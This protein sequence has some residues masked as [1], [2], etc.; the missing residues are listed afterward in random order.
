MCFTNLK[1]LPAC[2]ADWCPVSLKPP[3][4]S[5]PSTFV[6]L[7][8]CLSVHSFVCS[9]IFALSFFGSFGP[10]FVSLVVPSFVSLF[11]EKKT[12]REKMKP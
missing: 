6:A 5:S 1:R 12:R 10:P 11:S 2:A 9:F 3:E 8:F 4:I 7:F